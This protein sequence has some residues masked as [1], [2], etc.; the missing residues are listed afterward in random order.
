MALA[1]FLITTAIFLQTGL[2]TR[3]AGRRLMLVPYAAAF[4]GGSLCVRPFGSPHGRLIHRLWG[5]RPAVG[6]FVFRYRGAIE[7]LTVGPPPKP[8]RAVWSHPAAGQAFVMIPFAGGDP[9]RSPCRSGR[10]GQRCADHHQ[11]DRHRARRAVL[12]TVLFDIAGPSFRVPLVGGFWP[13]RL[14]WA[15]RALAITTAVLA[16]FPYPA[17]AL[18]PDNGPTTAVTGLGARP[19]WQ[20]LR[21]CHHL[22]N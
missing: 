21:E 18:H 8:R 3:A 2:R 10:C 17:V 12:G 11:T 1:G 15:S 5:R 19:P 9:R 22:A 13:P 6:L 14:C 4:L 20:P 7:L 16:G